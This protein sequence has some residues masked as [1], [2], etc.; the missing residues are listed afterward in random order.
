MTAVPARIEY[1]FTVQD[2][3]GNVS[4]VRF[5]SFQPDVTADTITTPAATYTLISTLATDLAA[6]ING[7]IVEMGWTYHMN[8]AQ[9][10]NGP[11]GQ[12]PLVQQRLGL[13]FG[14]GGLEKM[15][16]SIPTPTTAVIAAD[17]VHPNYT[18]TPL[19]TLVAAIKT[20]CY[21]PSTNPY[22]EYLGGKLILG[23]PRRRVNQYNTSA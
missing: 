18:A 14:D 19:S 15:S 6:C 4:V 12:Y 21:A 11:L 7:K 1:V 8:K 22:N 13:H 20:D 23:K 9:K 17:G 10:P 2:A 5:P 16:V 3:T